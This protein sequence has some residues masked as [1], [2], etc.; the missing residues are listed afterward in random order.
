MAGALTSANT[1]VDVIKR[2]VVVAVRA[3]GE[4]VPA[5]ACCIQ[6]QLK[7]V[8]RACVLHV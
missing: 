2:R 7:P 8:Q 5:R 1:F 6:H 3:D 4:A